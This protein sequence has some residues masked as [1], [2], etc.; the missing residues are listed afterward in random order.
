MILDD[1]RRQLKEKLRPW[2]Q[3]QGLESLPAYALEEPPSGIE[4]DV[5]CNLA[6][7]LAKPLKKSPRAVAEDLRKVLEGTLPDVSEIS[8]A[9][10]GFLNFR[11]SIFQRQRLLAL[12][13]PLSGARTSHH[14]R[15]HLLWQ[16]APR[17]PSSTLSRA[18]LYAPS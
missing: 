2:V 7:L 16:S 4:A 11:W 18:T 6:L 9:G 3:A 1:L 10:A 8:I 14:N 17:C 13:A 15:N 12:R 5:A